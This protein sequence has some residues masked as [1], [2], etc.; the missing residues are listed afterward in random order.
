M[1]DRRPFVGGNWKMN[2]DFASA[3]ELADDIV[4][5]IGNLSEECDIAVFP[6]FPY[7]QS[8]GRTLG[9]HGIRLGAQNVY[10]ES[11]GAFT[12]EISV[13]ML[14]DLNGSVV[15]IGHSERRHVI[16][17]GGELICRDALRRHPMAPTE[18]FDLAAAFARAHRDQHLTYRLRPAAQGLAD[19]VVAVD[20]LFD[21]RATPQFSM[22]SFSLVS[23][24]LPIRPM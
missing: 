3:V 1:T 6:P 23:S 4:A 11:N 7:L 5:G 20:E 24:V 2:T 10:H 13:D 19:G 17:E 22:M 18:S 21:A 14:L 15:L 12:G 16:G 8:V 9:H